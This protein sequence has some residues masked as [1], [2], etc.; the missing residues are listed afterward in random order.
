MSFFRGGILT[1]ALLV[2]ALTR[3]PPPELALL[4]GGMES[5]TD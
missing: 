2:P 1:L 3:R 5:T 4:P